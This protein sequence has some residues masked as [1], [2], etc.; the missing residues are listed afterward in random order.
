MSKPVTAAS[1]KLEIYTHGITNP[2]PPLNDFLEDC[3]GLIARAG[4]KVHEEKAA[5]QPSPTASETVSSSEI[6]GMLGT[7]LSED[8][9]IRQEEIAKIYS[10]TQK[11]EP[12]EKGKIS[13]SPREFCEYYGIKPGTIS[14]EDVKS[15]YALVRDYPLSSNV[16][17]LS[18]FALKHCDL[19]P[20]TNQQHNIENWSL[21]W[22]DN[23]LQLCYGFEYLH[24]A[25]S[26]KQARQ[27]LLD[28]I[29]PLEQNIDFFEDSLNSIEDLK[30]GRIKRLYTYHTQHSKPVIEEII[31]SH[32][33]LIKLIKHPQ[34]DLILSRY[35]IR[36]IPGI[37]QLFPT[38]T[39]KEGLKKAGNLL[40]LHIQLL[41]QGL[42]NM[43]QLYL[44][45]NIDPKILRFFSELSKKIG[46]LDFD[47]RMP[48]IMQKSWT[49]AQELACAIDDLEVT[50][51]EQ[52]TQMDS[53]KMGVSSSSYDD[54]STRC[55][56]T[57]VCL[58][59]AWNIF[60]ELNGS[61]LQAS[62]P[63]YQLARSLEHRLHWSLSLLNHKIFELC[64]EQ[65][66]ENITETSKSIETPLYR[67]NLTDCSGET[68]EVSTIE[69][70]CNDFIK[71]MVDRLDIDDICGKMLELQKMGHEPFLFIVEDLKNLMTQ[72][73][74]RT[75][76]VL[77]KLLE[78]GKQNPGKL[79]N[80]V[81]ETRSVALA[82]ILQ[83][84]AHIL[85]HGS[86]P[87]P[88]QFPDEYLTF[89]SLERAAQ[90]VNGQGMSQ[91][92]TELASIVSVP[93]VEGKTVEIHLP[94]QDSST[95]AESN[96]LQNQ[97]KA[98]KKRAEK[99]AA[100]ATKGSKLPVETNRRLLLEVLQGLG[101][102]TKEGG[103][104][105]KIFLHGDLVTTVPRHKNIASGTA[106]SVMKSVASVLGSVP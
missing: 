10:L 8:A 76:E 103:E 65:V 60:D 3:P 38:Q 70:I 104:H 82:L 64:Q 49:I 51:K 40:K 7:V 1:N 73:E 36:I 25:P 46:S 44:E 15:L 18:L 5:R 24:C 56:S 26:F 83:H 96:L 14:S 88:C 80:L 100:A 92:S 50:F 57:A 74:K 37:G 17:F 23:H 78:Y 48:K 2:I 89:L 54:A 71:N 31:S 98:S 28:C 4:K 66:G 62:D 86:S 16:G 47:Q 41:D 19:I 102:D 22:Q 93:S 61:I 97:S 32:K 75:P 34:G 39:T 45:Q 72:L 52:N 101:C 77:E 95:P 30:N 21:N 94:P 13:Y 91:S 29:G 43:D 11:N 58:N 81:R 27:A 84:D 12:L 105:T 99:K 90:V 106:H 9:L 63:T 67:N 68:A 53:I 87:W 42:S 69:G 20:R 59:W 35:P 33:L 79:Q 6:L 85:L 55:L